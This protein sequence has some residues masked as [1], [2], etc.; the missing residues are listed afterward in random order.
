MLPS[1]VVRE[2]K[3]VNRMNVRRLAKEATV[4]AVAQS[5]ATLAEFETL[6]RALRSSKQSGGATAL[7]CLRA[8]VAADILAKWNDGN[9]RLDEV[10]V[11]R[12]RRDMDAGRWQSGREVCFGIFD[13]CAVGD[14]QHR[15]AA[16][17]ASGTDQ[18][19]TVRVFDDHEAF[20]LYTATIDSGRIR[21]LADLL[22]IFGIA[23]SSA[24]AAT[25]ERVVNAMHA[26][27]GARA[28][29]L[30]KQERL[31]FANR[32]IVPIRYVLHLP[33]RDF[34]A[35]VLAAIAFAYHK[36]PDAVEAFVASVTSGA[37]LPARSPA[38]L[39]TKS[40]ADMN[41]ARNAGA[42]D[43]AMAKTLRLIHDGISSHKKTVGPQLRLTGDPT[44]RAVAAMVSKKVAD[45]Y[46]ARASK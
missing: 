43:R 33:R 40:I 42:K 7:V 1:C 30:S 20:A 6:L 34:K 15:F 3:R 24:A 18:T 4:G 28:G 45:D 38:L 11:Q 39:F 12:Y 29:R 2:K 17:V 10:S 8:A 35:H 23:E 19:Y 25:F 44:L 9:R 37:N 41:A 27:T 14:G 5:P 13:A 22:R 36:H 26:F 21:S 16:Q 46:A 32:Y 31:D